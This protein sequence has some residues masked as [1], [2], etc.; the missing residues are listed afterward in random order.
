MVHRTTEVVNGL[1]EVLVVVWFK[2]TG[3][4]WKRPF[5]FDDSWLRMPGGSDDTVVA[6]SSSSQRN[7]PSHSDINL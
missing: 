2:R 5:E 6:Q 3:Q 1:P 7:H 4:S